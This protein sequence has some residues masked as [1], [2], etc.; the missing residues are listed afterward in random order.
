MQSTFMKENIEYLKDLRDVKQLMERS[1]KFISLSGLSGVMAGLY[2]LVCAYLV[3]QNM[4]QEIDY[5]GSGQRIL[6]DSSENRQM[7]FIYGLST[8]VLAFATGFYLTLK[9]AKRN[10]QKVFGKP[11]FQLFYSLLTPL[12]VGGLVC[13]IL[14][15]KGEILYI[16]PLTLIFYGLALINASQ[17]TYS[18]I[19]GL[20]FVQCI[21]G[22]ISLYFIG[23]GLV[24]WSLGFGVSHIIYGVIMYRKYD[25]Q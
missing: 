10:Q 14:I 15:S 16:A 17:F 19:K 22:I 20:G 12:V 25:K 21:L 11:A 4:Y 13:L 5:G 7:M 18:D 1:S 24:F 23:Y 6:V 9:K 8:L 3:Y 2:A